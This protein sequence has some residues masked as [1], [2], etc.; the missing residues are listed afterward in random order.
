VQ[1]G[2]DIV[3]HTYKKYAFLRIHTKK[4]GRSQITLSLRPL[5]DQLFI[6]IMTTLCI[7]TF[8]RQFV[9]KSAIYRIVGG[10]V[11]VFNATFNNILVIS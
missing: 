6:I 5:S 3:F 2:L 8:G 1:N 11:V 10:R 9:L 7:A 4:N